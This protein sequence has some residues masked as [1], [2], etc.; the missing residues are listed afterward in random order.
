MSSFR[1]LP[2]SVW[3][4]AGATLVNRMGAMVFPFLLLYLNRG[5]H[6]ELGLATW[7]AAAW[8]V[9]SFLAGPLGGWAADRLDPVR[10]MALSMGC[11]G[12]MMMVFPWV[13]VPWLLAVATFALAL[14]A[15]LCR[16]ST[17]T[18]L[19]RLGGPEH[20]RNA[21]ALNYLAINLGMSVGPV[22]GGFLAEWDYRWLFWVDGST[23]LV[24]SLLLLLSG[25]ACPPRPVQN[26]S[27]DWNIGLAA[28]RL[29]FWLGLTFWV[30][31][32]FFAA[33]PVFAVQELHLR[34]RDCGYIWLFNTV[35]IVFT[36]LWLNRLT[37][38]IRLPRLLSAAACCMVVCYLSLW[39]LPSLIG[40]VIATLFLTLGEMLLFSN[41]NAYA[42][43]VVPEHKMGRAMG[44]NAICVSLAMTLSA[45]TVGYFFTH[46][47]S[48]HLWL[49]M[50]GVAL[51]AT[52]GF[53]GLPKPA[54]LATR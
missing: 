50:A 53:L 51:V 8:G 42:A 37:E 29:Y 17:L 47:C 31:M 11:A 2:R 28:F 40:L 6:L 30:F 41:A 35:L 18:A 26:L 16:P 10:L 19:A 4:V 39:F 27:T 54:G 24:A 36:T 13:R 52:V 1:Q 9:G 38:G 46:F 7:I 3:W 15:D 20:G 14:A 49:A 22:L 33:G 45:P 5:L 34:E 25:A 44:V 32:T 48:A 12:L 43:R 23:S 21:F